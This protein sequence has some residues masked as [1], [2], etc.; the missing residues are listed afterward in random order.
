MSTDSAATVRLGE[1]FNPVAGVIPS[2]VVTSDVIANSALSYSNIANYRWDDSTLK[3]TIQGQKWEPDVRASFFGPQTYGAARNVST[4]RKYTVQALGMVNH[5]FQHVTELEFVFTGSRLSIAFYNSGGNS[6]SDGN[7]DGQPDWGGDIQVYL[8]W[9]GRMWKAKENPL[10]TSR[11]DGSASF[12]NITFTNPYHG[13]IRI[14]MSASAFTLVRTDQS[15]IVAPAPPRPFAIA[16]GDSYFES[17]Q[18]LDADT[19]TGWFSSG[20]VDFLFE[21]TGFAFARRGQGA[22]GFFCNGVSLIH[23]DTFGTASNGLMSVTG[24]SR[25]LSSSRRDWMTQSVSVMA[26]EGRSFTHHGGEDFGQPLGRKPLFYLLNGTWNDAS[27][28]GVTQNQMY[29]RAKECYQWVQSVD[30]YCTFFHVGPEPFDDTLF[31]GVPL[32]PPQHGDISDIHRQGQMQAVA[33][34]PRTHYINPFGPDDPWWTGAGP[35]TTGS[36]GVPTN[37]QQAQL[38]SVHDGIHATKHGYEF[39][40]AK[41]VDSIADIQIPRARA[42]GLA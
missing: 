36:Q 19:T 11:T 31:S 6:S 4:P 14:H 42:E 3:F 8:E 39:Y 40:A 41:I 37:S 5:H 32:G 35:A 16:D 23:D 7:G 28:G 17:T 38:V 30:P 15:A 27:V 20:I 9:G 12:R 24:L 21:K 29:I 18:A 2:G 25:F 1:L 33:E 26:G 13:R 22:T 10:T 34:V